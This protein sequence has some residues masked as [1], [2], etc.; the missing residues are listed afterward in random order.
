MLCPYGRLRLWEK[1]FKTLSDQ[2]AD[3]NSWRLDFKKYHVF[4]VGVKRR[5]S[6]IKS[7]L[8]L[9]DQNFYLSSSTE[10]DYSQGCVIELELGIELAELGTR[11]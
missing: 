5:F 3:E 7:L 8:D 6:K 11:F 4:R 2:N 9:L 10:I 1:F